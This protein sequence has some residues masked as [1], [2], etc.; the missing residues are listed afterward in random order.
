MRH[1]KQKLSR[2]F[3][4]DIVNHL[5][6]TK[7]LKEIGHLVGRSESFICLVGKGKRNFT[8]EHL[9]MLEKS[10]KKPLPLI[11]FENSLRFVSE[12]MTSEYESL[13][14]ILVAGGKLRAAM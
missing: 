5:R 1:E 6:Q 8:I 3:S 10:L 4:S 13:R 11:I 7:T 2:G 12:E 9:F 14:K